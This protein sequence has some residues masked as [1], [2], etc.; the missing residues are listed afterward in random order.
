MNPKNK[1][2]IVRIGNSTA[3]PEVSPHLPS[4]VNRDFPSG[5][6]NFSFDLP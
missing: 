6:R 2:A 3:F 4:I 1:V 5:F